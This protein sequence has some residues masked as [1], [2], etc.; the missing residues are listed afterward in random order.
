[1]KVIC[2]GGGPA[3][4]YLSMLLKRDHPDWELTVLERNPKDHTFGF[5]VVFSD[6]TLENLFEADAVSHEA[7]TRAFAHWDTIDIHVKGETISSRGHGFSGIS[8]RKL[9]S[10]LHGRAVSLGVDVR[11]ETEVKDIEALRRECDLLVGAD[12][13]RSLVRSTYEDA[14]R[15]S[16]DPRKCKYIWLGTDKVLDAF[17]FII[18]ENEHGTF[19][20]HAY[21]YDKEMSTFIVECDR[22][23]W[24]RAGLD[25]MNTQES[26]AYLEGLFGKYLDGGRLHENR[27]NW[28]EFVTVKNERW[29]H[30]NVVLIGDAAHTAHFSIGSGTKL[31]IEDAIELARALG[32]APSVPEAL[33]LYHEERWLT[34]AKTQRAAQDSLRWF[35]NVKRYR[36]FDPLQLSFS[37]LTRSKRIGW[38]NLRLRDPE[39]IERVQEDF[40]ERAPVK[41]PGGKAVPP[42][43]MPFELRGM[44]LQN[45]VVVSPMCMYSAEDGTPN[46][47]HLMHL[48]QRALGGAG[49]VMA[50]MTN[51]SPEGRITPGC[52]GMY[53]EEHLPAWKRIVDFVH[54]NS[55]AKIGLQLG[56]AGRKG[57]TKR[58]WEEDRDHDPLVGD[59]AWPI[60]SASPIPYH[61][62]SPVPRELD[63]EGMDRLVKA[64]VRAARMADE[65]GFDLIEIHFAHGYL[66]SSFLSPLSNERKDD[67]GGALVKRMRFPM[68]VFEAVRAAWPEAK[69]IS[70]RISA[71]DWVPGGFEGADAVE[72]AR[73]L[74]AAGCDIIDVST[75]QTSPHAQPIYGRMWQTRFADQVRNEA[76]IPTIAVGN[77]T[78]ADQV[79]TILAA[80]RA[81]LCA[82]A[83][84]HLHDPH[85]TLRAAAEMGHVDQRWPN[86]YLSGKGGLERLIEAQKAEKA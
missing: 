79:N 18:E 61:P 20:V 78:T 25:R 68:E 60:L 65:A 30:E 77:I 5:G 13:I 57:S 15:P 42:M 16:L 3:G 74:R 24:E 85:W 56:H 11:F 37:L 66:L 22:E 1:M 80:G 34:V 69:P 32:S 59:E 33:E 41:H 12:G 35:E 72:V 46:D 55:G 2:V 75:G 38:E 8:R 84:P 21:R 39:F 14:F 47:F 51:V 83:R 54:A 23:S 62:Y 81:D 9:L 43:F 53:A 44:R 4:L 67:Y 19:Q 36:D 31:A 64:Y 27:S 73:A 86:P 29:H 40:A 71:T 10:I 48:G 6:E 28:I 7:I 49:L 17:T 70:V 82:L 52:T 76:K 45:R 63:R 58:P 26:I 50:E